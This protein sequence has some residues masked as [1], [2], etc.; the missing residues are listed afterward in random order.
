[1]PVTS[2]EL[3]HYERFSL[4]RTLCGAAPIVAYIATLVDPPKQSYLEQVVDE[5]MATYPM[6]GCSV[7]D[8]TTPHPRFVHNPSLRAHD[9][10]RIASTEIDTSAL[11][12]QELDEARKLDVTIASPWK[13]TLYTG[14]LP[15][16]AVT[17]NHTL[18]DGVGGRNLTG[19]LLRLLGTQDRFV[20]L[21]PVS[22]RA[23][24]PPTLESTIDMT[25]SAASEDHL[26][27][28]V[29]WPNPVPFAPYTRGIRIETICVSE[30]RLLQLKLVGKAHNV[31]TLQPLFQTAALVSLSVAL[32][33]DPI[34]VI[35]STAISVRDRTLGHP[36]ATGNYVGDYAERFT[37]DSSLRFWDTA[38]TYASKLKDPKTMAQS[39]RVMGFLRFIPN[40]DPSPY[41]GKT[42]WEV[43]AEGKLKAPSPYG[44][45][46]EL[47]NLGMMLEDLPHVREVAFSQPPSPV[48]GAL[49]INLIAKKGGPLVTS[50][51]WRDGVFEEDLIERFK[52]TFESCL[53]QLS[54]DKMDEEVIAKLLQGLGS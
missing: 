32:R 7:Q 46:L 33:G 39:K 54:E 43:W 2:R 42:G 6:L 34:D 53:N 48:W 12:K 36:Y 13:V 49:T 47:S 11:L 45:S 14:T 25:Q 26:E 1:M 10:V 4:T 41:P 37:L 35:S 24:L 38:S 9:I 3:G 20:E 5:M 29:C 44:S 22:D 19:H 28:N 23:T 51:V 30:A 27:K 18:C 50:I 52:R 40:P 16:I 8:S 31:A 21:T 15:R 17:L